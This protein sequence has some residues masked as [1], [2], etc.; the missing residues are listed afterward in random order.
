MKLIDIIREGSLEIDEQA[1]F[2]KLFQGFTSGLKN[3][4]LN[5]QIGR[6]HV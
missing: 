4:T 1:A 6:A 3:L 2:K 5:S